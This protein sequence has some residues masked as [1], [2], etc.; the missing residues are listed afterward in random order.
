MSVKIR[1]HR[2]SG[3]DSEELYATE[4]QGLAALES[5]LNVH[6]RLGNVVVQEGTVYTVSDRRGAFV[7]RSEVIFVV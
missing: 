7:Q 6:R 2:S 4:S 3:Q 5:N 1:T